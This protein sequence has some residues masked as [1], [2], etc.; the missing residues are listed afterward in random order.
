MSKKNA[1]TWQSYQETDKDKETYVQKKKKAETYE[2]QRSDSDQIIS[3][4]EGQ[5]ET[6]KPPIISAVE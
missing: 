4:E 3:E 1:D 6:T 5:E 2:G